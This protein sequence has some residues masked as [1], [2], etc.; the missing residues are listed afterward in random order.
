MKSG[1]NNQG[2]LSGERNII[3]REEIPYS[4]HADGK[5]F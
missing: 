2:L 5:E 3:V 4:D 1:K